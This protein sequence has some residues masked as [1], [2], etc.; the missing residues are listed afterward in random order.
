MTVLLPTPAY[1]RTIET[2]ETVKCGSI[3]LAAATELAYLRVL[4]FV[5]GALGGSEQ[6]RVKL[7]TDSS[8]TQLY[9]TGAWVNLSDIT[10]VSTYWWGW[11]ALPATRVHLRASQAYYVTVETQNYTRNADTFYLS[12]SLDGP[13]REITTNPSK[14][15]KM[16]VYGYREITHVN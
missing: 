13:A 1:V 11:I 8:Y 2:S 14:A 3:T 7:Y 9:A 12:L 16:Q 6:M 5:R 4:L 15:V 10:N